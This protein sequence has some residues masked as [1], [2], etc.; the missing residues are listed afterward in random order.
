MKRIQVFY[1]RDLKIQSIVATPDQP[2]VPPAGVLPVEGCE[3]VE[4]ELSARQSELSLI[5]LHTRCR[6]ELGD[7]PRLVS[8]DDGA[9]DRRERE[10]KRR[11]EVTVDKGAGDRS[12]DDVADLDLDRIPDPAGG[13]RL[14]VSADEVAD[15]V[16]RGYEVHVTRVHPV[17]PLDAGLT[18][19]DSAVTAW[20]EERVQGIERKEGS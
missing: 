13:V 7:P 15:L 16:E 4:I 20:L 1:T 5:E 12:L 19:D 9:P 8:I 18:V 14:L 2:D 3:S 11:L 6:I 17:R 10:L